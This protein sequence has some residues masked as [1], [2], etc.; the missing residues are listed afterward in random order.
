MGLFCKSIEQVVNDKYYKICILINIEVYK[1]KD[2]RTNNIGDYQYIKILS[3]SKRA[4]Y[5]NNNH[6]IICYRGTDFKDREDIMSD[7]RLV[8]KNV[9][10]DKRFKEDLEETKYINS[11]TDKPILL[12]G[13]SKGGS[14]AFF[15]AEL[16]NLKAI[17]FNPYVPPLKGLNFKHLNNIKIYRAVGDFVSVFAQD[18]DNVIKTCP[19]DFLNS[20]SLENFTF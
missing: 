3:D 13:H 7:I 18:Y 19:K 15:I 4:V 8:A 17:I 10:S 16:L 9:E 1:Q 14:F 2:E 20:H 5:E 12:T 6:V 11:E